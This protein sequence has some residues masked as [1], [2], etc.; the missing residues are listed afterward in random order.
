MQIVRQMTGAVAVAALAAL[1]A[2]CGPP[3]KVW[4]KRYPVSGR[5]TV[6]G[7][8]AVRA[9]ISFHPLAPHSDGL[10]Y[11]AS[12]FTGDD[13]EYKLTTVEAG[14]GAPPGEYKVTIV[15]NY[16]VKN[17]EDV[18]VP[19]LLHGKYKDA[20]TTPL[21]ATVQEAENVIPTF[22]LKSAP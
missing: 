16:V 21:Q 3:E 5:V 1:L 12:T 7:K 17:G 6:D 13:G 18:T 15:A 2:G 11:A 22:D 19:D 10:S 9:V 8:P 14:D 4:P 20:K